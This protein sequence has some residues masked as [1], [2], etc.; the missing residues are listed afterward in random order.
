MKIRKEDKEILDK[1]FPNEKMKYTNT[2]GNKEVRFFSNKDGDIRFLIC[3][4]EAAKKMVEFYVQ[5]MTQNKNFH[6]VITHYKDKIIVFM[7]QRRPMRVAIGRPFMPI[8]DGPEERYDKD[9]FDDDNEPYAYTNG[10]WFPCPYCHSK[11]VTTFMN[12]TAQCEDCGKE[13][14]YLQF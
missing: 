12:G 6:V 3:E 2:A 8:I 9:N 1:I 10:Q 13:Y 4:R 11:N 5:L 7:T 14:R